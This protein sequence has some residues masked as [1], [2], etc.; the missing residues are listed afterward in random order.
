MKI[1]VPTKELSNIT[2][3]NGCTYQECFDVEFIPCDANLSVFDSID[4]YGGL[5]I[6]QATLDTLG[7]PLG[8]IS[9]TGNRYVFYL[10]EINAG[11]PPTIQQSN[12]PSFIFANVASGLYLLEV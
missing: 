1:T 2:D 5:G 4:C 11:G 12:N 3:I 10:T 7:L 6:L 9:F 8:P